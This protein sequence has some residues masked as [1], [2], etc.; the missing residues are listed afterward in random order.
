ML[1]D[2]PAGH[3]GIGMALRNG[4]GNGRIV[5]PQAAVDSLTG[6]FSGSGIHN[7]NGRRLWIYREKR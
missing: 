2:I 5:L 6:L 3:S 1:L 4:K 7:T